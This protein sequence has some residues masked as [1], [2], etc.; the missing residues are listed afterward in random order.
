MDLV[1]IMSTVFKTGKWELYVNVRITDVKYWLVYIHVEPILKL[2]FSLFKKSSDLTWIM[3][4]RI[5]IIWNT[6]T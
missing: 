3:K 1:Y 2:V 4:S 5:I 6:Y